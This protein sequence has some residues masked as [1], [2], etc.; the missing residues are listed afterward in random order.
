MENDDIP[1]L[2]NDEQARLITAMAD[3]LMK[4]SDNITPGSCVYFAGYLAA[5]AVKEGWGPISSET[6]DSVVVEEWRD[7]KDFTGYQVNRE[8]KVRLFDS[9]VNHDVP[10][11]LHPIS[12]I[13]EDSHYALLGLKGGVEVSGTRLA[14]KAFGDPDDRQ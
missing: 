4:R 9:E 12:R 1:A 6:V 5:R 2:V 7:I 3:E 13:G 10:V 8:G 11:E 14:D